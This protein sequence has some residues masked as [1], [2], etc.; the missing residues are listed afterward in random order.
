MRAIVWT[1][2]SSKPQLL[3]D[4]LADQERDAHAVAQHFGWEVTEVL[5]VPGESR[6][7]IF[8]QDAE[9]EIESY[10]RFRELC[11]HKAADVLICRGRDRLGRTDAL[12]AQV[13][14]L[15]HR[16]GIQ[17]YSLAMPTHI[18]EPDQA[19]FDRGTLYA[20]AI[21]RASA[22]AE[23]VELRRRHTQGMR[24]R[25]KRGLPS[26][27][28]P[29]GYT[30]TDKTTPPA[31]VP[32]QVAVIR[33]MRELY[34]RGWGYDRIAG[35]LNQNGPHPPRARHWRGETI[36]KTLSNPFHAG[37]IRYGNLSA[38]GQHK[39]IWTPSEWAELQA[40]RRRRKQTRGKTAAPYNG[41]VRCQQCGRIMIYNSTRPH[42]KTTYRYYVCGDG[43]RRGVE[44]RDG[45][46][47]TCVRLELIREATLAEAHRLADPIELELELH[48]YA[49]AEPAMIQQHIEE[50][51][52][53]LAIHQTE[54]RRLL[55]AYTRYR[56]VG[57][58]AFEEAMDEAAQRQEEL[59]TALADLLALR[60][61]LPDPETRARQLAEL[62]S[63]VEKWLDHPDPAEA[64]AWLARRIEAIW[65]LGREVV[66]VELK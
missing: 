27:E 18:V 9:A 34:L 7:H 48:S 64:N 44:K 14:A 32:E 47:R 46:H 42:R 29:Y 35:W 17:I 43:A 2:V 15:A 16:A 4:S 58:E 53:Q 56:H 22:Q 30:S 63:D 38:P 62:A 25:I 28:V 41:L 66:S 39:P 3:G 54:I 52:V 61:E 5:S 65:C 23:L 37:L 1:A 26:G 50:V 59:E 51:E 12:I 11:E 8:Y 45:A 40:E 36:S 19:R 31:Q 24:G 20:A 49:A 57:S 21:E 6:S 10:R 60:D 13:E 33:Q 55:D